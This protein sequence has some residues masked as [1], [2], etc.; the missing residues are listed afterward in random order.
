[1]GGAVVIGSGASSEVEAQ[2]SIKIELADDSEAYLSIRQ[3]PDSDWQGDNGNGSTEFTVEEDADGHFGIIVDAVRNGTTTRLD[4]V[5]RVCNSGK[6]CVCLWIDSEEGR[7]PERVT[8]YDSETGESIEGYG[9]AVGLEV[10]ECVDIGIG[11]DAEGLQGR[12]KLLEG[13]TVNAEAGCPCSDN[14]NGNPG[15]ASETA[16]GDGEEFPGGNWF[17]YFEYN[18]GDYTTDLVSGRDKQKVGEVSVTETNGSIEVTY[19]TETD[20]KITETHL[21]VADEEPVVANGNEW[22][23]NGWLNPG[24][25]PPPGQFPEGDDFGNPGVDEATYTVDVSGMN[26]PVYVGAHAVVYETGGN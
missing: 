25:N 18:G 14:G 19:T 11:I 4:D 9:N 20:W 13:V 6:E 7:F 16:W 5:F 24:G 17:T 1:L 10:G 3:H 21:A 12:N 15:G 22:F 2:R 8:F 26:Y 23:D